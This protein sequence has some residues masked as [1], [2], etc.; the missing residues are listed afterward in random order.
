VYL[1]DLFR[2]FGVLLF[3]CLVLLGFTLKAQQDPRVTLNMFNLPQIN[4][5]VAGSTDMA[6]ASLV[7]RQQMHSFKDYEGNKPGP[8]IQLLGAFAPLK[9]INSGAGINFTVKNEGLVES[10]K[11]RLNYAY[12]MDVNDGKLGLGVNLGGMSTSIKDAKPKDSGDP[13]IT[14][15]QQKDD[16][17]ALDADLGVY[18]RKDDLTFGLS[19]TNVFQSKYDSAVVIN[20]RH[21]YA[22]VAYKYRTANPLLVFKPSVFIKTTG[23]SASTQI[24][25]NLLGQYN[26]SLFGGV[27]YSSGHDLSIVAGTEINNGSKFDGLRI[28]AAYDL[29]TSD[30]SRYAIGSFEF[31][32]SYSFSMSVEKVTKTYKSVRFL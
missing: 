22:N 21:Y 20:K 14:K 11:F 10:Y 13:V 1:K 26:K 12:Q 30:L 18:Y 7:I 28:G 17:I 8:S 3:F 19:S 5:A 24:S 29:I 32:L 15:L 2:F 16:M 25:L 27:C 4:P 23:N 9:K 31:M 6:E